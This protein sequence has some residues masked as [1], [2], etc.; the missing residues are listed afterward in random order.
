LQTS[1]WEPA[2]PFLRRWE[3]RDKNKGIPV[4]CSELSSGLYCSTHLWNVG[5]Q[6]FYTAV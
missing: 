2:H 4:R 3:S 1:A 6:S 5:R